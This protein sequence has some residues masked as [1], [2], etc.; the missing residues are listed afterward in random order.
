MVS[1]GISNPAPQKTKFFYFFA[2]LTDIHAGCAASICKNPITHRSK[3]AFASAPPCQRSRACPD[4]RMF[5]NAWMRDVLRKY[6][7]SAYIRPETAAQTSGLPLACPSAQIKYAPS[8]PL[9]GVS[10]SQYTFVMPAS[11][12]RICRV[13]RKIHIWAAASGKTRPVVGHRR[14]RPHGS[15]GNRALAR[16]CPG[17]R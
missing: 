5:S 11:L 15:G 9:G 16:A 8:L 14:L 7:D 10:C 12:L 17:C 4:K 2:H 6:P 13:G 1:Y 3:T